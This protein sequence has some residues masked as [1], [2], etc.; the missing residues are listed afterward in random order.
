VIVT[1]PDSRAAVEAVWRLESAR[2]VAGLARLVRDV[3]LAEELAQDALVDA[4]ETWPHSGIPAKPGAWLM[5]TAK[6]RAI[7]RLRRN[8]RLAG[9]IAEMGHEIH[10][11]QR[12]A[13]NGLADFDAVIDDDQLKDDL[14]RLIFVSCHPASVPGP[15]ADRGAAHRA[16][17]ANPRRQ[18]DPVRDPAAGRARRP[19]GL[20]TRG[21]LPDLQ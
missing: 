1:A 10:D 15:R 17:Q 20:G 8:D 13:V 12:A 18:A 3:G 6:H 9:R 11:Q 16:G 21:R 19:T 5:I 2:I 4:L 14:L 7:D